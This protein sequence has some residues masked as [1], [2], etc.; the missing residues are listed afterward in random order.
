M[1]QSNN[2]WKSFINNYDNA[3]SRDILCLIL[4]KLWLY[5]T[6][7]YFNEWKTK[8]LYFNRITRHNTLYYAIVYESCFIPICAVKR[9][10]NARKW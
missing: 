9:I 10:G 4:F 6:I 2:D 7:N 3:V 8:F 5:G 1:I